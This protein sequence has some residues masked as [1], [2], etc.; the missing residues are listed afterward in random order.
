VQYCPL[1]LIVAICMP[2]T[3]RHPS[4]FISII[5]R[6][7]RFPVQVNLVAALCF[8]KCHGTEINLL[9]SILFLLTILYAILPEILLRPD[10]YSTEHTILEWDKKNI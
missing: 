2:C 9:K 7:T 5:G 6:L 10:L 8:I 3:H 4:L 1:L